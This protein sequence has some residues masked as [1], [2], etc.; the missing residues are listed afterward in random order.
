MRI[1]VTE[2]SPVILSQ[3]SGFKKVEKWCPKIALTSWSQNGW[4]N[5][6]TKLQ[7][8]SILTQKVLMLSKY[9]ESTEVDGRTWLTNCALGDSLVHQQWHSP[10]SWNIKRD[11]WQDYTPY[12]FICVHLNQ[13]GLPECGSMT[14]NIRRMHIFTVLYHTLLYTHARYQWIFLTFICVDRFSL[15]WKLAY[16]LSQNPFKP[17]PF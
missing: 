14:L 3:K 7:F 15:C 5:T 16:R 17:F 1:S 6:P 12:H 10:S 11:F 8:Q 13:R 9:Y 4:C 2:P